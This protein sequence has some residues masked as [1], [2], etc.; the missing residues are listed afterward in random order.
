MEQAVPY[1]AS[2]PTKTYYPHNGGSLSFS[3][4]AAYSSLWL[5]KMV[6]GCNQYVIYIYNISDETLK[7]DI[8]RQNSGNINNNIVSPHSYVS[9]RISADPNEIFCILFH[10]PSNFN[11]WISCGC[12]S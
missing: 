3:G 9:I 2:Y 7:Y 4:N 5:D 12:N 10:A 11:G 6:L 1:G 8:C